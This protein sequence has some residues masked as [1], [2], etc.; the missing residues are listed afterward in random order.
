[1]VWKGRTKQGHLLPASCLERASRRWPGVELLQQITMSSAAQLS[2]CMRAGLL[3]SKC[4][5]ALARQPRQKWSHIQLY[6][7]YKHPERWQPTAFAEARMTSVNKAP[8]KPRAAN[9]KFIAIIAINNQQPM[10]DV[11]LAY[12]RFMPMQDSSP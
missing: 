6:R 7:L 9:L 2:I 8:L 11:G 5:A 1:M 4:I 12:L 10:S 3:L